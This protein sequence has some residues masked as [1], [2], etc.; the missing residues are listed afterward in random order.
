MRVV[1]GAAGDA[2]GTPRPKREVGELVLLAFSRR[3]GA[4]VANR[5]DRCGLVDGMVMIRMTVRH[6]LC[7]LLAALIRNRLLVPLMAQLAQLTSTF[8]CVAMNFFHG[9]YVM[10]HCRM[11]PDN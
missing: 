3:W 10:I 7:A 5:S 2:I 8:R 6:V 4:W 1:R 11:P 9:S